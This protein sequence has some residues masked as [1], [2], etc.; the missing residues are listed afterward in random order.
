MPR[1][2]VYEVLEKEHLTLLA[3]YMAA[4]FLGGPALALPTT[5]AYVVICCYK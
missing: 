1:K 4:L 3:L 5:F 2:Q